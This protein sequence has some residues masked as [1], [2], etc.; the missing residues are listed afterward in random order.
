MVTNENNELKDNFNLMKNGD[1]NNEND[2]NNEV[3]AEENNE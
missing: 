3:L 1:E 2:N